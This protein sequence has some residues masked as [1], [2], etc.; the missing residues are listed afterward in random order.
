MEADAASKLYRR[1][2]R[3]SAARTRLRLG[4]KKSGNGVKRAPRVPAGKAASK[5]ARNAGGKSVNQGGKKRAK[6]AGATTGK[7]PKGGKALRPKT[8]PRKIHL[9]QTQRSRS[10]LSRST[11]ST[12]GGAHGSR[13][14][15]PTVAPLVIP[16]YS[17]NGPSSTGVE[18][19]WTPQLSPCMLPD[20]PLPPTLP[21]A[22]PDSPV[23]PPPGPPPSPE[24][25][26]SGDVLS[27]GAFGSSM[28][29]VI[30]QMD[31]GRPGNPGGGKK[32]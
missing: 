1:T 11:S 10:P 5:T 16:L 26:I 21:P 20:I 30:K 15:R 19:A 28:P 8:G 7:G 18:P 24:G 12:T 13:P 22:S 25:G 6:G 17:N 9:P 14:Q 4:N 31:W 2:A 27:V 23:G 29:T 32:E 3:P